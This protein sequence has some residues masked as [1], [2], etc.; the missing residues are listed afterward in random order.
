MPDIPQPPRFGV[1]GW[2]NDGKTTLTVRLVDH[3]A[4]RGYRVGTLKH[5]AHGFD[6]DQPGSDSYRH[7][8][9]GAR[10]VIVASARRFALMHELPAQKPEPAIDE[11]IARMDQDLDL[12]IIEGYKTEP[13]PKIEARRSV[14]AGKRLLADSDPTILAIASDSTL[15]GTDRPVFDLEDVGGMAEF[16][17]DYL[18]LD[19]LR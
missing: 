2:K 5:A 6:V 16:M 7:R 4:S 11:L 1:T 19:V 8:D 13:H 15:D 14:N 17:I 10:E 9:A 12:V 18:R 3:F